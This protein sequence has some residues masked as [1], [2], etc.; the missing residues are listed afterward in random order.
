MRLQSQSM[1]RESYRQSMLDM[2]LL[3]MTL[4]VNDSFFYVTQ[5]ADTQFQKASN[6]TLRYFRVD[7][8]QSSCLCDIVSY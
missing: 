7:T 1:F 5:A 8:N 6:D 2:E 4:M 3:S